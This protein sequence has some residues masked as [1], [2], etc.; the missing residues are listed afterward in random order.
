MSEE[1]S[2]LELIH[3]AAK[4]E[5][6][7]KGFKSAS[8]RNIVKT[9]GVTTGAF[10]GYYKSKEELF[11]ALVGEQYDTFMRRYQEMQES[12]TQFTPQQQRDNIEN[13]SRDCMGWMTDYAYENFD[14]FKMILCC[15]EGTRYENMI[16][17][18]VEIE[19][20]STHAY[21]EILKGLGMKVSNVDSYLE[22]MLVS[23][24]FSSYFELIIHD[25]SYE[26]AKEYVF[27]LRRFYS[28]G[29]AEIMG[30]SL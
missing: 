18:M 17:E 25:V 30:Y 2:T 4:V 1:K 15:S 5:F 16:H 29:W 12:F 22:H 3:K 19:I 13:V 23:G 24:L 9:A 28:A 8:L 11:D 26:K 10:Y 27:E 20:E 21:L 6:L 14:A 7:E